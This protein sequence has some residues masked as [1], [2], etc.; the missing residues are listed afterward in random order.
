MPEKTSSPDAGN[1]VGKSVSGK[2]AD[3]ALQSVMRSVERLGILHVSW[4]VNAA[5]A[6]IESRVINQKAGF[7]K[8]SNPLPNCFAKRHGAGRAG[9]RRGVGGQGDSEEGRRRNVPDGATDWVD[10]GPAKHIFG[11][12]R[13][14]WGCQSRQ[15]FRGIRA[16]RIRTRDHVARRLRNSDVAAATDRARR[17]LQ[18]TTLVADWFQAGASRLR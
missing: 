7:R 14:N 18:A 16:T 17:S 8:A 11:F 6:Q 10:P 3:S 2:L 13:K 5:D 1:A 12:A 9:F 4:P 15:P